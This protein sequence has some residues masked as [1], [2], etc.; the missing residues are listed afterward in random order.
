VS[1]HPHLELIIGVAGILAEEV[2][3]ARI[4]GRERTARLL[5]RWRRSG[6]VGGGRL[7]GGTRSNRRGL[8][9]RKHYSNSTS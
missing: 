5:E 8:S 2:W 9:Y 6:A 4:E 7:P 3:M 1:G